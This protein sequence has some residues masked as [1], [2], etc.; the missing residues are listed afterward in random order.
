MKKKWV[1]FM[2]IHASNWWHWRGWRR[3]RDG[4]WSRL[5]H[6]QP[7]P[8]ILL[9]ATAVSGSFINAA[10]HPGIL[11]TAVSSSFINAAAHSGILRNLWSTSAVRNL[12]TQPLN[13]RYTSALKLLTLEFSRYQLHPHNCWIRYTSALKLL[14]FAHSSAVTASSMQLFILV[15]FRADLFVLVSEMEDMSSIWKNLPIYALLI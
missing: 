5:S 11:A 6:H 3:L 2:G 1:S 12:S 4:S 13:R 14:T 8:N 9:L 7:L 15:W 10:A